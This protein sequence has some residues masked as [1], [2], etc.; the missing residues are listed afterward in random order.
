MSTP[1]VSFLC[2]HHEKLNRAYVDLALKSIENLDYQDKEVILVDSSETDVPFPD[3]VKVLKVPHTTG[4]AVAANEGV[5]LCDPQ[6][7][8]LMFCNDDVIFTK[9]SIKEMVNSLGD[10]NAIMNAFCN[11]DTEMYY[12]ADLPF[13]RF[14][15]LDMIKGHE[16][17]LMNTP[18]QR[19]VIFQV[20]FVCFYAT[21]MKIDI[22]K[23]LGGLDEKFTSGPDDRDFCMRAAKIGIPS[24]INLGATIWHA[25]GKTIATKDPVA[26]QENRVKNAKYFEEK[27]NQPQ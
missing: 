24:I 16:E 1:K 17:E 26:V 7:K 27:W 8:Y 13:P 15:D 9:D 21:L 5:K 19:R 12:W 11:T 23:R 25:G 3:W 10:N 2:L 14:Y 4:S 18:L 20:P 6:A 22:W